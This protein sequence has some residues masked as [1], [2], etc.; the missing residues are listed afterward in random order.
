MAVASEPCPECEGAP[1]LIHSK[2]V[3]NPR[4]LTTW[5]RNTYGS[6]NF[7]VEVR[8]RIIQVDNNG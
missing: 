7:S 5:L 6:E 4:G 1:Q 3:N 8:I 2:L